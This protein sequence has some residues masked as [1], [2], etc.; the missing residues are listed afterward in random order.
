MIQMCWV[1]LEIRYL[2]YL[3]NFVVLPKYAK[4]RYYIVL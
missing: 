2:E 3:D 4:T 1:W